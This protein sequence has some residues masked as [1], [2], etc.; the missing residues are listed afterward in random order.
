[1]VVRI[2][3]EGKAWTINNKE[4]KEGSKLKQCRFI[5]EYINT[6]MIFSIDAEGLND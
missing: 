1:M 4:K 3:E 5:W 6:D 2:N